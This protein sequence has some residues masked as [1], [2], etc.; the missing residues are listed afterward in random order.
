MT[1]RHDV[2]WINYSD[3]AKTIS[4]K[5]KESVHS[6]FIVCDGEIDNIKGVLTAKVFFEAYKSKDFTLDEL[7]TPPIFI[8]QN[9]LAFEILNIFKIRKQY[10]GVVVD[11]HGRIKGVVTL[12]DLIEAIV[13]DLPDEDESDEAYI[14][15]RDDGSYLIDGRTLIYELNQ[16]FQR[17][18]IPN[19][20]S[21]YTTISGFILDELRRI[22]NSGDKVSLPNFEL[23]IMDMDG[24]RIDK[25]LMTKRPKPN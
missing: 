11:E 15:K 19:N 12:H 18:V 8:T 22:P 16:Y 21:Q 10:I 5:L 4:E 17:E 7:M 13:G 1:N 6:K 14:F 20:I 24:I 9:T 23:E 25:I 3:N 2:E